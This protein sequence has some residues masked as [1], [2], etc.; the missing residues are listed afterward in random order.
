VHGV[1]TC[2]L[3]PGQNVPAGH[4]ISAVPPGQYLPAVQGEH[5]VAPVVAANV[6]AAHSVHLF[7][8]AVAAAEPAGQGVHVPAA[9]K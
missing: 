9:A 4:A 3:A 5:V 7:R 1:G 2:W 8:P 6:P